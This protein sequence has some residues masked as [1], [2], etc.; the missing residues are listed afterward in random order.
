MHP[1]DQGEPRMVFDSC[2]YGL[3]SNTDAG[4]R[5]TEDQPRS[6]IKGGPRWTPRDAQAAPELSGHC[7]RCYCCPNAGPQGHQAAL[8]PGL[9]GLTARLSLTLAGAHCPGSGPR[10]DP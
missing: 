6:P 3:I 7:S 9:R 8:T 10:V 4:A 1:C 5:G 2:V